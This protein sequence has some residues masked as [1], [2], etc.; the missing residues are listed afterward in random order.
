MNC[1]V[2]IL[3]ITVSFLCS[4]SFAQDINFKSYSSAEGLSQNSGYCITQDA[5]G[6]IWMGTQDGLNRFNG[7]NIKTYYKENIQRGSL[8]DNFIKSLY[9]DSTNNWLWIGTASGLAIYNCMADSFYKASNYFTGGDTLNGLMIRSIVPGRNKYEIIVLTFSEGLFICNT[10]LQSTKQ[11]FQQNE[12]K[13]ITSAAIVWNKELVIVCSNKMYTLKETPTLILDD[14]LLNDVRKLFIWQNRLWIA[15]TKSGVLYIESL[16][17]PQVYTFNCG[18]RDAGSFEKDRENNLWIGTRTEGIV[19]IEPVNY[20]IIASFNKAQNQNEWPKKFTLSLFIDRQNNSWVGSSGG[21][22]SVNMN[23]KREFNLIQK[24]E[25]QYGKAAHN[26]IL[27][28]YK[29]PDNLLYLGTQLEGLRIYDFTTGNT[30]TIINPLFASGNS[31][32]SITASSKTAIWL[33]T[34]AGLFHYNTLSKKLTH[35]IDSTIKPSTAGQFVYKLK[36]KDSLL[37]SSNHGTALFD[38]KNNTFKILPCN[39]KNGRFFNLFLHA[40]MEDG[41]G[42]IWMGGD[43]I[44]L[45]KYNLPTGNIE[46]VDTIL[47]FSKTVNSILND[48]NIFWLGTNNGII[49]YNPAAHKIIKT[50]SSANGLPGGVIYSIEKDAAGNFWCSSNV[51]LIKIDPQLDKITQVKASAGLQ[52]DEFN[53]A[54]SAKDTVGNLYFG[55]INGVTYFNPA[56]LTIA[57]FS[58]QPIIES[59]SV[60]NKELSLNKNIT[61]SNEI[62]LLHDQNFITIGYGANNFINHDECIFKYRMD[63]ADADWVISGNRSLANYSGLKP[64]K[65]VFNLQSANSSGVWSPVTKFHITISPAWWQSWW[66]TLLVI[67]CLAAIIVKLYTNKIRQ[68]RYTAAVKQQITESEMAA[69]K[70]QMNPHFMFNCINSIDAFIHS[71]DKYNATL[72]LNKFAKLLRNILESSKQNMV[73]LNKDIETLKLYI[74]LEELRHENKFKTTI[75]IDEELLNNDYKVPPLIIQPFVENAILHG[76]KNKY[77]NDGILTISIKKVNDALRYEITDNGI[78]RKAAAMIMQNKESHYGMQMSYDRIRLFNKEEKASVQV[79]DL[80]LDEIPTGTRV[81]LQLKLR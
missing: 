57:R 69:L 29:A 12:T 67:V 30:E 66:F 52:G 53:T 9:F 18:S 80:Y 10:K 34:V 62:N 79:N 54:C 78:G 55:G 1:K 50:F 47:R 76:L 56:N 19:I 26:L 61:Y 36:N 23:I 35:Y 5:Q 11:F 15:S 2:L 3:V 21:G 71:N 46:M 40:V 17:K 37:Y 24:K 59:I 65:Y 51:G 60:L 16:Y 8:P 75:N 58:P 41:D 20:K 48:N 72:Y 25:S 44:G 22:F 49:V 42:N 27:G 28:M 74:E 38:L 81:T 7:Q 4:I 32:Y 70:A 14:P 43:G 68:V 6:F 31:V 45:T 73:A 64:G 13:N 77:E 63:G 39:Y 33:A